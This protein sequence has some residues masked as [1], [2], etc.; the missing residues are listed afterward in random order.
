MAGRTRALAASILAP[1]VVG[2]VG[3][4]NLTQRPRFQAFHTV[5]VLQLLATGMCYGVA[6]AQVLG[7]LRKPSAE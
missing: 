3:F 1:I 2:S 4:L 5:D 6:L 7:L